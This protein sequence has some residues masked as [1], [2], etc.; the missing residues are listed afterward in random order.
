MASQKE[1]ELGGVGAATHQA[2]TIELSSA[3]QPGPKVETGST[4]KLQQGRFPTA[5]MRGTN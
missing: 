1:I 3:W 2:H 4:I 5:Q